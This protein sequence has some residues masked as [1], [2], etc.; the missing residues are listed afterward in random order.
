MTSQI[1]D[2][3]LDLVRHALLTVGY[4]DKAI[5]AGYDFAVPG[6]SH[7]FDRV[8]L[9]AFSDPIRHDLRTSCI[10]AHRATAN[11]DAPAILGAL[12]YLA[13]PLALILQAD[14]V[15][16]WPV[17]IP[18][19]PQ[20][21][22]RISYDRLTQYFGERAKDLRPEAL[23][24]AKSKGYQLSLYNLDRTLLQFAYDSTQDVLV[25]RFQA[26][27]S[28]AKHSRGETYTQVADGLT[29]ASL[30][31]LAAA[32]LEDKH[33]LGDE[34]SSNVDDLLRRSEARY[35][36]Y[37]NVKALNGIGYDV[38]QVAFETLRHNVTFRSFTNEMLGY[39]Y[40]HAL[41]DPTLRKNLGVY[42]TPRPIAKRI[43]ERLP[44]EDIPPSDRVVFDG[45]CG[46]GNLL[47][48]AY[49]RI[50]ELLPHRWDES[51]KHEYLVQRIHGVD[52]DPFA[53]QV[54]G[55]SL[56]FI[57]LPAG[58]TWDVKTS[59]FITSELTHLRRS[60]TV[61]VGN[62]PFKELRSSEGKRLQRASLFLAKY[63]DLLEP[64]G[65]LGIV[66][67]E[68]FLEN[69]SCR[70]AR[71]RLFEEC[72]IL[73]LWHLPEGMF[74]M[75]SAATVVIL[76]KKRTPIQNSLGGPV[77]VEKVAALPQDKALFLKGER[78]RFSYIVPSTSPWEQHV[79]NLITSSHLNQNIWDKIRVSRKFG[80]V[81]YI[82]NGIIP[83]KKQRDDHIA[84]YKPDPEWRPWLGGASD[85]ESYALKPKETKYVRYPGN[86]QWPREDLESV[87]ATPRSKIVANSGRAPGNPWR[88]YAAIDDIG[89]FPS[90]GIHCIMT[91]DESVSLEE[92]VAFLNSSIASAW[93]DSWNRRRWIDENTLRN[94]PFP[95][96]PHRERELVIGRVTDLM[97]LKRQELS[98]T[99]RQEPARRAIHELVLSID[100]LVC[101]ALE[102]DDDAR[103]VLTEYFAGYR[104]PGIGRTDAAQPVE[105]P[106]ASP[107]GRKWSVT[108]QVMEMDAVNNALMLWVRGYNDGEPFRISI[109]QDMPGWALRKETV[110]RA[111]IAWES[112][113]ADHLLANSLTN[114]RPLDFS[115][116]PTEE[117]VGLLE[118]PGKLDKLY[119][120]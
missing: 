27:V 114:F 94:M 77:K 56:F 12:S 67:P 87:F 13:T 118:N 25:E 24:A 88:L 113:N 116:S 71:S 103:K 11:T 45:S 86:L 111:E 4:D 80:D 7:T 99:F 97:T 40:E 1:S 46:S 81:A 93:V 73:E 115:Y 106:T 23:A 98:G 32:I 62:P 17:T 64:E 41:V 110:F 83:G 96:F 79:D 31:I 5:V 35:P 3:P 10:A 108:G 72:D 74:P 90:Q 59:D 85:F 119:E 8:D 66:L 6:T 2:P 20:P 22:E 107:D 120:S 75:S 28:A 30:Q 117:L 43:L 37:F 33:L 61:V 109:P 42:Y 60:P 101:D 48:A 68:T 38:A 19:S 57:D 49:E 50:S 16:L 51:R 105:R 58:D 95:I 34:R 92:I 26:A 21:L 52:V 9:A 14:S 18:P 91:E 44:I 53:T 104:R 78:P 70:Y 15:D 54:A 76:A 29:K 102:V 82:R 55:L 36:Q 89:Y 63:L 100:A 39:F 47:L 112:R 65:L 84:N 69:S